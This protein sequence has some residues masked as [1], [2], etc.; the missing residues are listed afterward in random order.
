STK[1]PFGGAR[2]KSRSPPEPIKIG[3]YETRGSSLIDY[4]T[5]LADRVP[6][7]RTVAAAGCSQ[8]QALLR[9]AEERE[10]DTRVRG[11]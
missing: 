7:L 9:E 5:A 4:F 3:L 10:R 1:K 8:Q 2:S 6:A 11:W